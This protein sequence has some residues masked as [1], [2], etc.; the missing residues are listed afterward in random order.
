MGRCL[1]VLS[2]VRWSEASFQRSCL[3]QALFLGGG[4]HGVSSL[5]LPNFESRRIPQRR[6]GGAW[7]RRAQQGVLCMAWQSHKP[8]VSD[9]S[10]EHSSSWVQLPHWK[11]VLAGLACS[12]I[13]SSALLA[14]LGHVAEARSRLTAEEKETID[15][16]NRNRASVVY[17]TN[18]AVRR[19]AFTMDLM[20]IP[21]GAGSGFVYDV[22][23]HIITN[24]HVIKGAN[25]LQVTLT[26]GEE[27]KA[28]VIGFDQDKDIAV[29]KI[30]V[31]DDERK[32]LLQPIK[33]GDSSD[34][35][36]GQR[37]YAIG[38]PFGLDHTLTMGVISGTGREI[39]SGNTGRPIEDV[40]QTDAA[41]NPG[42]SGGPLLDSAGALIGV[43]TAIFS[44]SGANSGVGFAIPVDVV[45]SSVQQ[46]I[47]YGKVIRPILGIQFAPDQSEQ[48]SPLCGYIGGVDPS[49]DSCHLTRS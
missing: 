4:I 24:Y 18:L 41:I 36:V 15:I 7:C 28:S 12:A 10:Q 13:L 27:Y 49:P 38:N 20:A 1:P 6:K 17:I 29:L 23:G 22:D 44:P 46:I 32:S 21:Q 19:D 5:Q 14:P 34:L 45:K 39:N 43:N 33:L 3:N 9:T 8:G 31:P 40:I 16:F 42:N 35:L 37:V 25:D 11:Q 47:L 26:E 48:V 2:H 30:T